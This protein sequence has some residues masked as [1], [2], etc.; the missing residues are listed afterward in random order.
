MERLVYKM[1]RL[2]IKMEALGFETKS[3]SDAEGLFH[4]FFK[5]RG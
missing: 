4:T 5:L 1:E 3:E 2:G